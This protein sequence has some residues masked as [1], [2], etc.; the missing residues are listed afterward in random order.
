[1][2]GR[3]VLELIAADGPISRAEVARLTG[4]SKPT[5]SITL[6]RLLESGVVQEAG[7]STGRKGPAAV[8]YAL[9]PRVGGVL[10]VDLTG[11]RIRLAIADVA[12]NVRARAD[13]RSR[14]CAER[15]RRQEQRGPTQSAGNTGREDQEHG[16]GDQRAGAAP[17]TRCWRM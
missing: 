7:R 14:A 17:P 1:M 3:V 4:M 13:E 11:K 8:L 15:Q 9:N 16:P 10:A 6:A 12:G 5:A 2:N